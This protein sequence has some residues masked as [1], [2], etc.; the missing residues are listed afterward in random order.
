MKPISKAKLFRATG[1]GGTW[2]SS[3][4]YRTTK[5]AIA[6]L[7]AF[8]MLVTNC[9]KIAPQQAEPDTPPAGAASSA[10]SAAPPHC[11]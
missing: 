4:H 9:K 8:S 7:L 10:H 1:S 5:K 3:R 2:L 6:G 11:R